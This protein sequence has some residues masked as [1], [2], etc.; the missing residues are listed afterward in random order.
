MTNVTG[1]CIDIIKTP[2]HISSTGYT[3]ISG[4]TI[5]VGTTSVYTSS[6]GYFNASGVDATVTTIIV[7]NSRYKT[8]E[9]GVTSSALIGVWQNTGYI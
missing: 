1:Y 5:S 7:A 4:A 3:Y 2:T 6:N 9:V 8:T